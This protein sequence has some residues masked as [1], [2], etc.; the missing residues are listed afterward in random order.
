MRFWLTS[1]PSG[2]P[3]TSILKDTTVNFPF[4]VFKVA[5]C[6]SWLTQQRHGALCPLLTCRRKLRMKCWKLPRLSAVCHASVHSAWTSATHTSAADVAGR[7]KEGSQELR[8][9]QP[10]AMKPWSTSV[11]ACFMV[12]SSL[13]AVVG[14]LSLVT[15]SS[16][17]IEVTASRCLSSTSSCIVRI[18]TE[19]GNAAWSSRRRKS[20]WLQGEQLV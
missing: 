13:W 16:K 3:Q 19:L 2:R 14:Q 17:A 9:G 5:F 15:G 7:S 1:Q 18:A 4:W 10:E 11:A 8:V 20:L 12:C 6:V